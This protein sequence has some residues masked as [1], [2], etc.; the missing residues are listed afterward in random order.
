[1]ACRR[2]HRRTSTSRYSA[3]PSAMA[4]DD[5]AEPAAARRSSIEKTPTRISPDV[6]ELFQ[7]LP[8]EIIEQILLATDANGFAS[9]VLVSSKW[10]A[11]S[12]RPHL[13]RHH[14]AQCSSYLASLADLPAPQDE[15]LPRLR[16]L[17]AREAKRNLFDSYLRPKETVIKLVSNSIS[18]SSCPGGEGMQFGASPKGHHIL[19]YNS[20]RIYVVDVRGEP[21]N[22]KR[23]LKILRRPVSACITDDASL[24]AVLSTEMQVDLYDLQKTPPQRKQSLILDNSPRTIALSSCGS[25]LAAAYDGG[26]EVSSLHPGAL[27]TDRRAVKCD[28]VDALTFSLDGTQIL[29]TTIHS[30]PPNTVILTAPYY[31]PGSQLGDS[32]LSAMW[33]T[34]ILF[35][36]T[37]RDC[38]HA[39]LLQDGGHG[40][41]EWTFTY[42]RSFETFRAVRLDD[43]RN[44]TTYFT[45]PIPKATS[46]SKLLPCTLP[47]S[48]YHGELVASGFQGK[49][50]WIYGVPGDLD[51]VPET[52]SNNDN[53]QNPSGLGRHNSGQ[54]N[55][56]RRTSTRAL[57][58]DNER[59]AQWQILCDKLRNN[60]VGGCKISEHSG[61]S[62]V[63][64]VADF[65]G[66]SSKE[67]LV[68]T[69]RGVSGPRLVTDE[70][71]IDFVD[72]GRLTL[73]DF[74]YGLVNGDRSEIT[75]EVGTDDAEVLEE[76]KR[77]IETE[78]AIVRR[79]TVAQQ[80]GG[81]TALLRAATTAGQEPP[82]PP[83]PPT[84]AA[85]DDDPL[86]P[87]TIG[88][89]PVSHP[90]P[91]VINDRGD[92]GPIEEQEALD[93]PYAHASPRSGTTLRRAAT[94]AAVN[95][96]LNPRTADGRP[97]EY[98]RADGRAEHPHESDADNWVPPPPPYQEEEDPVDLPAFLR[99]PSVA[100]MPSVP[101]VPPL[102][103]V[104]ARGRAGL[105][106]SPVTQTPETGSSATQRRRSHRRPASDS[107]TFS[108]SRSGDAPSPRS[109][110]SIH[111]LHMGPDDIYNVSPPGSPCLS[112]RQS[113]DHQASGSET[114][115]PSESL[116][117]SSAASRAETFEAQPS[118]P[119]TA[120]MASASTSSAGF[121]S[122]IRPKVPPL[123]LYIPNS[124]LSNIVPASSAEPAAR[125]LSNVQTW[126]LPPRPEAEPSGQAMAGYPFSAPP[127]NTTSHDLAAAL[128]PAPSSGQLASL[129]KRISQGNPRRLSGGL[130]IQQALAS[131]RS[132]ED[133]PI[134]GQ[135][136]QEEEEYCDWTG[137]SSIQ[138]PEFDRPLIISTPKGVSGAFDPPNR[139][140]SG[141]QNET[142][143]L[144]PIPRHPRQ[145]NFV[146]PR[147]TTERLETI[148]SARSYPSVPQGQPKPTGMPSWLRSGSRSSRGS[149]TGVNRRPSRAERSAARNMKDARKSGWTGKKS[150]KE[151]MAG[152]DAASTVGWTDMSSPSAPKGKKCVVM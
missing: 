45:G 96:R 107:T 84:E 139:R 18:S 146:N 31:D 138:M 65:A 141:R 149:P 126:P 131:R 28:A 7:R 143:I 108:R 112:T 144:A 25:V 52:T 12:Q 152:H 71:D 132:Y 70:E 13:Y 62:N 120:A 105:A 67:R 122:H 72:G 64:W 145:H 8:D 74:D 26:I 110:P 59:V 2:H 38:S 136:Q 33:T 22:V 78:V 14:L 99:G 46:Q 1:M 140:T 130:Q 93:A 111:S 6:A 109:S 81:R 36:N 85:A 27:A 76:E 151:S 61:V 80:R 106:S 37:S 121:D 55:L 19:A 48:T 102:P 3:L 30:S 16:R 98:R 29:G 116:V 124:P 47:A 94:A 134:Q 88:R 58:G 87:R 113:G 9:L 83:L 60:F 51:A 97:I 86:V 69:A 10:R 118:A 91:T 68:V 44:G 101:L 23:E 35:P 49:E 56:S 117:S 21:P 150:K 115:V 142:Q 43:L 114:G 11:V 77:D 54:S 82:L 89:N 125:R 40:E 63:K 148:Y 90:A 95:R 135:Q 103:A 42:D 5:A 39:I 66:V 129:N 24:L 57:D 128:P 20:S 4:V 123:Q 41:A 100:P 92:T 104:A 137:N 127:S 32:N 79:R 119:S 133:G 34:S 75:I 147:P 15:N 17:F 73:L 50:V 53:P